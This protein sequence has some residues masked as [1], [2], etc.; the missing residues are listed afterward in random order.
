M[1][2]AKVYPDFIS[3]NVVT[4]TIPTGLT[5]AELIFPISFKRI[6]LLQANLATALWINNRNNYR[7][8]SVQFSTNKS[9]T[10]P[11]INNKSPNT[12][13]LH[14]NNTSSDTTVSWVVEE[15]GGI[16]DENYWDYGLDVLSGTIN[17]NMRAVIQLQPIDTSARVGETASFSVIADGAI[18]KYQWC[19]KTEMGWLALNN[20]NSNT[21]S[22]TMSEAD[23]G[24]EYRCD[25]TSIYG[26]VVHSEPAKVTLDTTPAPENNTR[27]NV[28]EN[29][30]NKIKEN[31]EEKKIEEPIDDIGEDEIESEVE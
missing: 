14:R 3:G 15:I 9:Y 30:N 2:I 21:Y 26:E 10:F 6:S 5:S 24:N 31:I 11:V 25:V 28:E 22:F 23:D 13:R 4:F 27:E 18:S 1:A 20:T 19:V 16:G 17:P 7:Y 8:K 12:L 29:S